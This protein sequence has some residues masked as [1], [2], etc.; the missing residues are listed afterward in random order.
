MRLNY[1]DGIEDQIT[2][3]DNDGINSDPAYPP[4]STPT[5]PP[6]GG[7]G[8][9]SCP[10]SDCNEGSGTQVD[11]CAYGGGCPDG[12]VNCGSCCQPNL[13]SPIIVD[14]DGSGFHLSSEADGVWF[15]FF[16]NGNRI[17]ISWTAISSSNAFLVL[18][19][20]GNGQIDSG[21]ELFG[22]MTPQPRTAQ[23]HGFLALSEFDKPENGGDGDEVI[24]ETDAIFSSLRLWQDT[25]HNAISEP[26]ELHTLKELG[27]KTIDLDWKSSRRVDEYGNQFRYRAKV[28]D[29]H[30]AQLGR[31]AWDVFL[32]ED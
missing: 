26:T 32:V 30:D 5:P 15:D 4:P 25:D 9:S 31:W 24:K 27:L 14:V 11:N 1:T 12:Y 29:I 22:N 18:D 20:N 23:A 8:G 2:T 17:K 28:K 7:G 6:G 16:G 3:C 19:R 21:R 10:G 13:V